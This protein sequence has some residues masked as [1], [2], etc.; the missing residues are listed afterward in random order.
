MRNGQPARRDLSSVPGPYGRATSMGGSWTPL[1]LHSPIPQHSRKYPGNLVGFLHFTH[2]ELLS[3][4]QSIYVVIVAVNETGTA[5]Q[6]L[7]KPQMLLNTVNGGHTNSSASAVGCICGII[8]LVIG[9]A[10]ELPAQ[11]NGG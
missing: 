9:T 6:G 1:S 2:T 5:M 8:L 7:V 11:G 3:N 10:K 4:S